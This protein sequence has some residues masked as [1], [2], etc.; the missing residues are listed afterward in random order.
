MRFT[1]RSVVLGLVV[2]CLTLVVGLQTA[3]AQ[4]AGNNV[5]PPSNSTV[6]TRS[7]YVEGAVV[8]VLIAGAVYAVGRSSRRV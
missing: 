3:S 7:F 5:A 1:V 6:R 4:P 8:V 2:C